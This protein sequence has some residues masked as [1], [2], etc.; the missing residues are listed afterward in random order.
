MS[1]TKKIALIDKKLEKINNKID[2]LLSAKT[3]DVQKVKAL[4][5][6]SVELK[7]EKQIATENRNKRVISEIPVPKARGRK[8]VSTVTKLKRNLKSLLAADTGRHKNIIIGHQI[9]GTLGDLAENR[10]AGEACKELGINSVT[11]QN[12]TKFYRSTTRAG[13][14]QI[15]DYAKEKNVD[16]YR[17]FFIRLNE[18]KFQNQQQ[19]TNFAIYCIDNGLTTATKVHD[20]IVAQAKNYEDAVERANALAANIKTAANALVSEAKE[21]HSAQ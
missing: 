15:L 17:S 3:I 12:L 9:G 13:L 5:D 10:K 6:Q 20:T 14:D 11:R 16:I 18:G 7:A 8:P 4:I 2:A 1:N 19:Y 21:Q